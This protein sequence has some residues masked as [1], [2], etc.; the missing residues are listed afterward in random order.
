M[1]WPGG[2]TTG[3]KGWSRGTGAG[4]ICGSWATGLRRLISAELRP[5]EIAHDVVTE[6]HAGCSH[7]FDHRSEIGDFDHQPVPAAS[8]RLAAIGHWTGGR[9]GRST[10]PEAQ[11]AVTDECEWRSHAL[12]HREA[13]TL[14]VER[15]RRFD[16]IHEVTDRRHKRNL[17]EPLAGFH[18]GVAEA[19]HHMRP[20][21]PAAAL[22]AKMR[23]EWF[24]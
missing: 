18:R 5:A 20:D 8:Q 15:H 21:L 19:A 3:S 17:C 24:S 12:H 14:R 23:L 7:P 13:K 22:E 10:Q 16:I 9:A 11:V 6:A 1:M 4:D 2:R